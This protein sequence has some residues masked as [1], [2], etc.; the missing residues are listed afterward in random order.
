MIN[1]SNVFCIETAYFII[2]INIVAPLPVTSIN[3]LVILRHY[4]KLGLNA[5]EITS[6]VAYDALKR[7]IVKKKRKVERENNEM[8]DHRKLPCVEQK[9][10]VFV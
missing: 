10:H 1:E 5:D 2:I 3:D 7:K 8:Q 9:K 6:V 4:F